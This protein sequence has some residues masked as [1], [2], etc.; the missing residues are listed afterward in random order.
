[1]REPLSPQFLDLQSYR[2]KRLADA[3]KMIPILGIIVTM[4]P[5]PYLFGITHAD[6]NA[7]PLALYLFTVW[8]VLILVAGFLSRK[9]HDPAT[10]D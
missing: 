10:A 6:K 3:A 5:L 2:R 9:L 1:M 4:F 7:L 8:M